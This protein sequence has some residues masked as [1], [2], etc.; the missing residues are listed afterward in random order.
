MTNLGEAAAGSAFIQQ[1]PNNLS[2]GSDA[3]SHTHPDPV[4]NSTPQSQPVKRLLPTNSNGVSGTST[5]AATSRKVKSG[6]ELY[7]SD[8]R[9]S[10][11][12][13]NKSA[14]ADGTLNVEQSLA[15]AW[16][17][18]PELEKQEYQTRFESIKKNNATAEKE[19]STASA[20]PKQAVFDGESRG[21]STVAT[22]DD[23]DVEMGEEGETATE[24]GFTAV[25]RE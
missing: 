17:D 2:P 8:M 22:G 9:P 19:G 13:N 1:G 14:I 16:Q 7:V 20:V 12:K 21:G 4:R 24:G 11:E 10:M 3:F 18:L 25:N 5:P 23:E 6:F 15:R